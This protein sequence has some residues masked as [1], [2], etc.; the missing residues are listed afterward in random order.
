MSYYVRAI[1]QV[2]G[3]RDEWTTMLDLSVYD[4]ELVEFLT[5]EPHCENGELMWLGKDFHE[6]IEVSEDR[7]THIFTK[8]EWETTYKH[9]RDTRW[10]WKKHPIELVIIDYMMDGGM[11][12]LIA[13]KDM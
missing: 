5:P 2:A 3:L 7:G 4:R 9:F 10:P 12:R 1:V 8:N 6:R 11:T 13:F